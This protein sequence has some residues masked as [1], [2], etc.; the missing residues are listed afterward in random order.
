MIAPVDDSSICLICHE[1]NASLFGTKHDFRI[2][3]PDVKNLKQQSL[4][5]SGPC[6]ACHTP[7]DPFG[8][9]LWARGF[10]P[11][12][13]L[14]Q[15]CLSCHDKKGESDKIKI[16]GR[17]SHPVNV[18]QVS[19]TGEKIPGFMS[20]G[21][22][23]LFSKTGEKLPTGTVECS[24][25]HN[26]HQ[27]DPIR[28]EN[29]GGKDAEGSATDSFL[30]IPSGGS[31]SLCLECHTEKTQLL[32]YDHNLKLTAP[33]EKNIQGLNVS[34]SGPCGACHMPH[35]AAGPKLWARDLTTEKDVLPQYCQGCH[36]KTGPA[37]EKTIGEHNHPVD[38]ASKGF[39][40][41]LPALVTRELPLFSADGGT[42][43]GETIRCLTCHDPHI[44]EGNGMLPPRGVTSAA[45]RSGNTTTI[46]EGDAR[47][48]F[49]RK[50]ASPK[51]DLCVIC[52]EDTAFLMGTDHDL[53]VTAP[54]AE[55][56]MGQTVSESGP[57]GA[58]HAIHNSPNALKLWARAYGP[59][60]ENQHPMNAL[61][62]SC[63]S[64]GMAAEDKIPSVAT[65]PKGKLIT[66]I[67]RFNNQR[68]GYT[69]IFNDTGQE[70]TVG[71]LSCS[72]CHSYYMWDPRVKEKGSFKNIEGNANTS[73]LRTNIYDTVCSDCHGEEAIWRYT[74]FHS[75][76]KRKM[77]KDIQPSP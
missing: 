49:L 46:L 13:F 63:H 43:S 20:T 37:K 57:C 22:L 64:K 56:L 75:V 14:S 66:N 32:S 18:N 31:S 10:K 4:S 72:S 69:P 51:P 3:L 45:N 52:H 48:S 42:E 60:E 12:D 1:K 33:D 2:T 55:N 26:L 30:R 15:R 58:C 24:S 34:T 29:R 27:W 25:C 62:T 67:M 28:P 73:F 71:D 76:Q 47:N 6:G 38:V 23:P 59:V 8:P 41:A 9:K 44:W 21:L 36:S 35:N 54:S 16:T 70:V 7:H 68:R 50:S 39:N 17:Y 77:L 74:Y 40:I 53:F 5:V 11:G 61:C 65:H 19:L